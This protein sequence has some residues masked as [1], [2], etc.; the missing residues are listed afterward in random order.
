TPSIADFD[1]DTAVAAAGDGVWSATISDQW[2]V[3]RGPNGGYIAA[4]VLRALEAQVADPVRAPRSLTLHYL[5]PPATGPCTLH[6]TVERAGRSLTSLSARLIQ[7]E[8]TMVVAL[9]AFAADFPSVADYATPAPDV[10]PPPAQLQTAPAE[11]DLPPIA[12]RAAIAPRFGAEPFTGSDEAVAGGWLRLAEPRI[13]DAAAL[14]FYADAWLP[15]PF[16]RLSGPAPAPTV[17]LTIHFRTRLPH[18]GM[19]PEDPVLARFT[20]S[21]SHGGFFEEDGEIWAPDGTLL[22]QCRQLALLFPGG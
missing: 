2:A 10:G 6:V 18:P 1:R 5:R 8:R 12:L 22:V 17:D 3:P 11:L 16:A 19:A 21:T 4:M 13:A 14:A 15:T 7:D 20:S 9:G